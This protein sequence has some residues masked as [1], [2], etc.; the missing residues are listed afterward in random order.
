[1]DR[2]KAPL[3]CCQANNLAPSGTLW[4]PKLK[5]LG[6]TGRPAKS[7]PPMRQSP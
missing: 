7:Q 3:G 6:I 4:V 2:A 5:T 1:M